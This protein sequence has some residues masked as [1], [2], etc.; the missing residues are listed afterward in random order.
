MIFYPDPAC[1]GTP[2]TKV[3]ADSDEELTGD[4][5]I[6]IYTSYI[7][8]FILCQPIWTPENQHQDQDDYLQHLD[9]GAGEEEETRK[10]MAGYPGNGDQVLW[11]PFRNL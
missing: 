4:L 11:F 6:I 1:S 8:W 5:I 9:P 7:I 3:E 2:L 10:R